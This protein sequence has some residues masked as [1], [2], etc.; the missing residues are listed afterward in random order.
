MSI[1]Y[2]YYKI[3]YYVGKY[4]SFSKAAK[5]LNNSQPN[6]TRAMNNLEAE[7]DCQLFFRSNKGV[8]LT[9]DG[10]RLFL[11]VQIAHK[12]LQ[13][14]AA[15]IDFSKNL[16][17][18]SIS[19]GFSIGITEIML[20]D[21]I[22]PILHDYHFLYPE[23]HIQI[24]NS[25]T[26]NLISDVGKG[27]IDIAVI[28]SFSNANSHLYEIVLNSFQ[29]IMIAGSSY[30]HLINK[31]LTLAELIRYPIVNLWQGT[32][33]YEFYKKF[34]SLHGLPFKPEIETATTDQVLSFVANNMGIGFI[35]PEY[36]KASLK[37]GEVFKLNL[38]ENIPLRHISLIH[39][40]GHPA[41][42][43]ADILENMIC[44]AKA[45]HE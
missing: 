43:A 9:S 19:I 16:H 28:T 31:T 35:S 6:I 25:S 7:L 8:S 40:I 17:S 29:D 24:V 26:P 42:P 4:K 33:T 44:N 13:M 1:S 22:L 23:T 14:G 36:A 41:N 30:T 15:E 38:A 39:N 37:K 11:H 5:A 34:F 21:R 3:F 2:E 27:L 10:E 45:K 12:E 18:A 32:E 20:H